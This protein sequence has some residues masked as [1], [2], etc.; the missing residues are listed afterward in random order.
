MSYLQGIEEHAD[1][2]SGLE[3][4][5]D[6]GMVILRKVD[7]VYYARAVHGHYHAG[8]GP[9]MWDAIGAM[10]KANPEREWK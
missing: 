4:L 3:R 7:G 10:V 6:E 8:T 9:T 5:V 1:R 2:Q